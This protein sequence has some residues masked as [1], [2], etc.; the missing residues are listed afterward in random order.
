MFI[1]Y[2]AVFRRFFAATVFAF[3]PRAAE[4]SLR[5]LLF[6]TLSSTVISRLAITDNTAEPPITGI[7][8]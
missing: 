5:F 4:A 1:S 3:S 6:F 8:H 7:F 2:Y